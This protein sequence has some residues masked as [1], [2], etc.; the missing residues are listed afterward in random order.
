MAMSS[1]ASSSPSGVRSELA[2]VRI[3][4][5]AGIVA[6]GL[7][8]AV[9]LASCKKVLNNNDE[10]TM[11]TRMVNLIEDS[12]TVQYKIE[13]TVVASA[14]YQTLSAFNSA[15]TGSHTISFGAIRPASLVS[16]DT[17]DPIA[18][19]GTFTQ[20]YAKDT[21]YTIFAYGTL[22]DVKTTMI[23]VPSKQDD[24]KDDFIEI[25]FVDAAPNVGSI[26]VLITAPEGNVTTPESQG[27]LTLGG[28]TSTRSMQL[29]RR[30]DVTDTTA[31]L[32]TDLTIEVRDSATGATLLQ[33]AK[34]RVTEQ[35][36]VLFAVT[37]NLGPGPSPVQLV[38]I[39]G[40]TG[41]YTDPN[42]QAQVRLVHVSPDTPALN[43][44]RA[45]ALQTPIASN[46]AF[47]ARSD[48]V[49]V[50][51]GDVDLIAQPADA[52][53]SV[54]LFL[55]EFTAAPGL[56]YSAYAIGPL[57]SVDAQ[58]VADDRRKVPTQA[59]FRFL[60]AAPSQS[61]ADGLDIYVTLPGQALDFDSTDDKDTTDD[62][63]QFLRG[64]AVLYKALTDSTIYKG[65]TYQVRIMAAGTSRIV[66]DTTITL[67]EG[68]V[69]TY[70]IDDDLTTGSLEMFP[71]D[72][73]I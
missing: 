64:G 46:I 54:L 43:I 7:A 53:T 35:T 25:A 28:K 11:H 45:S 24:L 73:A 39:D 59:K 26:D 17:T 33:S 15:R 27:T 18:L 10:D 3:L 50:A 41:T 1:K 12:P 47:G 58:M 16:G 5:F 6:A 13:D 29:F 62:A 71:V 31:S 23:E 42:D 9:G 63:P 57:A 37:K 70:V 55:E 49:S 61:G 20:N 72:E 51:N 48:Y 69:Q 38:G 32:F 68:A 30:A 19:G 2:H 52:S 36:R 65:G 4:K 56:S 40:V 44:I 60:N 21:D 8:L 34:I 67:T 66:L 14:T 22:A